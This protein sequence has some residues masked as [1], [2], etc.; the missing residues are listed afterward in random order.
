MMDAFWEQ[1]VVDEIWWR[2]TVP[3]MGLDPFQF[4]GVTA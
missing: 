3:E 4:R 1:S 2:V